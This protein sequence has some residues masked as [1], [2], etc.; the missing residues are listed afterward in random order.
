MRERH[1]LLKL[2][3]WAGPWWNSPE[4]RCGAR[5]VRCG[6]ER[7]C[8]GLSVCLAGFL[9]GLGCSLGEGQATR[10]LWLSGGCVKAAF[11]TFCPLLLPS[12]GLD[13]PTVQV[14]INYNTPGLPKIYIHRVGRTA[15]AGEQGTDRVPVATGLPALGLGAG[16]VRFAPQQPQCRQPSAASCPAAAAR[17]HPDPGPIGTGR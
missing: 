8:R 17:A 12:R 13:I 7:C 2:L 1:G 9:P 14:V 10:R 16:W 3:G 4:L 6:A 15:R 11:V 5:L